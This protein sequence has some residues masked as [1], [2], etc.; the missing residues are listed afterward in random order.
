MLTDTEIRKIYKLIKKGKNNYQIGNELRHSPNTIKKIRE[1]YNEE[2]DHLEGEM[3]HCKSPSEGARKIIKF[4]DNYVKNEDLEDEDR[5]KWEKC[6]EQWREMVKREV[7]D[8]IDA[9]RAD[10]VK[11]K[12]R[13]WQDTINQWYVKKEIATN[14]KNLVNEKDN[15]IQE[16]NN[17]LK[18]KEDLENQNLNLSRENDR[19]SLENKTQ[20]N[21]I[22]NYLGAAGRWEREKLKVEKSDNYKYQQDQQSKLNNMYYTINKELR[23][24]LKKD[25]KFAESIKDIKKLVDEKQAEFDKTEKTNIDDKQ[26]IKKEMDDIIKI[27]KGLNILWQQLQE[28]NKLLDETEGFNKFALF[29]SGCSKP[30]F[31]DAVD[32]ETYQKTHKFIWRFAS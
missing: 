29:C 1:E 30:M 23:A 17:K 8:R 12:D 20:S 4:M 18:G 7:D 9:E 28:W 10:A 21:Y 11:D 16:L 13:E 24:L 6:L 15:T 2:K 25:N 27:L 31:F 5:K 26:K 14:L 32:P 19:L 22:N 3:V